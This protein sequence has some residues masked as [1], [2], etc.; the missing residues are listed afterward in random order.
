MKNASTMQS[1][2]GRRVLAWLC[3]AAFAFQTFL[4][5]LHLAVYEH[6]VVTEEAS[7]LSFHV[8]R[9]H[10]HRHS[11]DE[12]ERGASAE[13]RALQDHERHSA[14]DHSEH[15]EPELPSFVVPNAGLVA[16]DVPSARPVDVPR[17]ARP[18]IGAQE[19]YAPPLR[20][21]CGSRAPPATA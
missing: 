21:P 4:V 9:P 1:R 17:L 13:Q 11:H 15:D 5:P 2:T 18:A 8:E 10:G 3:C 14:D 7:E 20:G 12:H 6:C 16:A 19:P